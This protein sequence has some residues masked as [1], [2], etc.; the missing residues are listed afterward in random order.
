MNFQ[1]RKDAKK[2]FKDIS[3]N[4]PLDFDLYYLCLMAGFASRRRNTEIH[5][6][7]VASLVENFPGQFR[8]RG[9]LLVGLLINTELS[10][11]G[12]NLHERDSVYRRVAKWVD[13]NSPSY[14][15][16]EGVKLM[17][18]YAHGGF[19]ALREYFGNCPPSVETFIRKYSRCINELKEQ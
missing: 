6:D 1:L 19:D 3:T 5:S 12:I 14:M 13:P 15:S 17:N 11:L 8:S 7:D 10:R 4:Y 18:Q 2:W 16:N 9:R